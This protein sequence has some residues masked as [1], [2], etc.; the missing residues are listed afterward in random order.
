MSAPKLEEMRTFRAMPKEAPKEFKDLLATSREDAVKN[1]AMIQSKAWK[2]DCSDAVRAMRMMPD[3]CVDS[4]VTDPPYPEV[5]RPYGKL[6]VPKW[7]E[8]MHDVVRESRRVLSPS[9]SAVFVL[10]PNNSKVGS[11]R[12]WLFDFIS[13]CCREW[14]VVQDLWWH[15]P[16]SIPTVHCQ[17][18]FGLTKPSMKALVWVGQPDCYRNQSAVLKEPKQSAA[19]VERAAKDT[20]RRF[21]PSGISRNKSTMAKSVERRGGGD[22]VQHAVLL[23]R[24]LSFF[25]RSSR[26]RGRN[27]P[28]SVRLA[29]SIPY[30]AG[31][32]G[33]GP[34]RW[35]WDYRG[36]MCIRR[37]QVLGGGERRGICRDRV[38]PSFL[39]VR[40]EGGVVTIKAKIHPP[41]VSQHRE[42]KTNQRTKDEGARPVKTK[43]NPS[44][45]PKVPA[46]P[47][48]QSLRNELAQATAE[49]G[50]LRTRLCSAEANTTRA[51]Y[52]TTQIKAELDRAAVDVNSWRDAAHG[53]RA[54]RDLH[55]ERAAKAEAK[56][57][58]LTKAVEDGVMVE[59]AMNT[60]HDLEVQALHRK[61]NV[62]EVTLAAALG[63]VR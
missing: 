47:T 31:R 37:L 25:G 42:P 54:S 22:S 1:E 38:A 60:R 24:E 52:E 40:L 57:A 9:G 14:N 27:P 28:G 16:T 33:S 50:V 21:H 61:I 53:F 18:K 43:K 20:V 36:R 12:P 55:E 23:K 13:W 51:K 58:S 46:R 17:E 63:A 26:A 34:V 15:N 11:L 44:T 32:D 6:T 5:N 48:M 35:V 62:L 56:V 45:A 19:E 39:G 49:L 59:K 29:G 10:Q 41:P 7:E 30:P 2:M 4:I 3:G 8:M